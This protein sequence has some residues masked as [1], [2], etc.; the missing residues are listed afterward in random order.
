MKTRIWFQRPLIA[1]AVVGAIFGFSRP[2]AALTPNDPLVSSQWYLEKIGAFAAWDRTVG[3]PGTVLAVID[4]GVDT[5]HPDLKDNI[6]KNTAELLDGLDNDGNGYP[7]DIYGWNFIEETG[8]PRSRFD[9]FTTGAANHGT[10]IAGEAAARGGNGQGIAGLAWRAR[11]MALR[12]LDSQGDGNTGIIIRAIDYAVGNGADILGLSFVGE[13]FSQSLNDAI[14]RATDAGVL[15]VA[16]AGNALLNGQATNLDT[17]PLYPVCSDGSDGKNRV[18]GVAAVDRNDRRSSFSGYG[19]KCIDISAPGENIFSTQVVEPSKGFDDS[20]GGG[21]NGSS[22]AVPLVAGAAALLKSA[23]PSLTADQIR[24]YLLS[25]TDSI[26]SLNP[27]FEGKLGRGR[28]NVS[29]ALIAAVTVA[30]AAPVAAPT[31]AAGERFLVSFAG[32]GGPSEARL[33][34]GGAFVRSIAVY[35]SNFL[36]GV[37][38][39]SGDLDGDGDA[40]IVTVPGPGGGPHVRVWNSDGTLAGQFFA[41]SSDESTGL[42][43]AVGDFT[44]DGSA[45]IA[46]SRL[47]GEPLVRVFNRAGIKIAEW[48]A[49]DPAFRGGVRLAAGDTDGNGTDEI[50]VVPGPGGRP[51]LRIM[52]FL[53]AAASE[54]IAGDSADRGGLEVAVG[55]LDGDGQ[56]EVTVRSAGSGLLRGFN[57]NGA[58]VHEI[59]VDQTGGPGPFSLGDLDGDGKDEIILGT[60]KGTPPALRVLTRDGVLISFVQPFIGIDAAILGAVVGD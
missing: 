12:A 56:D 38:L 27:G 48:L 49:Y 9:S 6:W 60:A 54:Y 33:F 39:A 20:Y 44:G 13:D 47:S 52:T 4:T 26:D 24:E 17:T 8:D 37:S 59:E 40:E 45:E 29:K 31:A 21:W 46:V 1:L 18:I 19:S 36:G 14:R 16:A 30:P 25:N 5:G 51:H 28:L 34:S 15:V 2:M 3:D 11:I 53:G 58:L 57:R 23:V 32:P 41:F 35:A 22:L 10:L 42:S 50:V 7:D 55:D 43:V